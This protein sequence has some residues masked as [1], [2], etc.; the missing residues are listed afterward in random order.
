MAQL[1]ISA[2]GAAIGFVASGFNPVGA[3]IGWAVGAAIG[4]SVNRPKVQ[5][6]RLQDLKVGSSEYG[7][8]IPRTFGS[9]RVPGQI[10]WASE[11]REVATTTSQGKG[12]GPEVT[13]YTYEVDLLVGLTDNEILSV[14]R[15]WSNGKLIYNLLSDAN[16][17]TQLA[18]DNTNLWTRLQIYKG[19]A[20]AL[21]DA[22]YESAV[23][24][25]NAPS[26]RGRGYVFIEGLQLGNSGQLPNLTFEVVTAGT[27][28]Y[29]ADGFLGQFD[30]A[31][32][33]G[34]IIPEIGPDLTPGTGQAIVAS[35]AK[36]ANSLN[37]VN[38]TA[39]GDGLQLNVT[40]K[41]WRAE[42]WF[43]TSKP[44]RLFTLF[45]TNTSWELRIGTDTGFSD[46]SY[47]WTYA[48][49]GVSGGLGAGSYTAPL[50]T[51]FHVA[52]QWNGTQLKVFLNGRFIGN[53]S[54]SG[55]TGSEPVTGNAFNRI[56]FG[57]LF[58]DAGNHYVDSF[59]FRTFRA[60]QE[61]ELYTGT[62]YGDLYTVPVAPFTA[63]DYALTLVTPEPQAL[64]NV[65]GNICKSAGL[66]VAQYAT[67]ELAGNVQAL[68][69][70]QIS[71][72]RATLE[73]LAAA[74]FFECSL[75]D[76]LYFRPRA[77][78]P[79]ETI[80]FRDLAA[81]QD[82]PAAEPLALTVASDLELPPQVAVSYA[83]LLDDHQQGTEYS[84]RLI[85]GQA[86][87]QTVQLA[88]GL[89]PAEAKGIADAIIQDA[90]ASLTSTALALPLEYAHLEA[91]DVV[92]VVDDDAAQYRLRLVRKRDEAGVLAFE[93]VF[94]DQS[95]LTSLEVTD[96]TQAPS[97][98][99]TAPGDTLFRPLDIPILRDADDAPGFYVAAKGTTTNWPGAQIQA[100]V[101]N[102]SFSNI[103]EVNESAVFGTCTTTLGNYT[104]VGFDEV[105]SVTVNVG[106]GELSSSTRDAML[107]DATINAMLI[108]SEVIR[109]RN[110][111]LSSPG[112]YVLTGLL[113][114]QRG[115]EWAIATHAASERAVLLRP[116]GLRKVTTQ[117]SEIGKLRYLRAVTLGAVASDAVSETFT[118]TGEAIRPFSPV[119]ARLE[120][121]EGHNQTRIYWKRRTRLTA[122]ITGPGGIN[123]PMDYSHVPLSSPGS[124][125]NGWTSVPT[126]NKPTFVIEI[127]R[128]AARTNLFWTLYSDSVSTYV[129]TDWLQL[130]IDE[131][132]DAFEDDM[133][134][135][136]IVHLAASANVQ[137]APLYATLNPNPAG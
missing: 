94:D 55:M 23:G 78:A 123:T 33:G 112:V 30:S 88:L 44:T 58:A 59:Q 95:A 83:N 49:G 106:N 109:F 24:A 37:L 42:G 113:R 57:S 79:V 126:N 36:F 118:N 71:P 63:P 93:A 48:V 52:A 101:D 91:G 13:N 16:A 12:G 69:I 51:W 72:A 90:A 2:A 64:A 108:G 128:D 127:Y 68:A 43:R 110:A 25:A 40:G 120:V 62:T 15:V 130:Y 87:T 121:I 45:N 21:P 27:E 54:L 65:V 99:V 6:P 70:T 47:V 119:D 100:S 7:T 20:T 125:L 135:V 17:D 11:K 134:H 80:P 82:A 19:G 74:Y 34:K 50:N 22:V 66:L 39:T 28:I 92:T 136:S 46:V 102:V 98:T 5:G 103:A 85:S 35:P 122:T 117:A 96:E 38:T 3:Q 53:L 61:S 81:A 41:Y 114:G 105:T 131:Y 67:T 75:R 18:S 84:D 133:L 1:V 32:V 129:E 76:K 31:F 132:T 4:A 14:S 97:G 77:E 86:A 29:S 111:T 8:P 73:Q 115:T 10:W 56:T 137:S 9:P 124:F 60:G 104:G 26:Y 107:A 89:T 116:Q